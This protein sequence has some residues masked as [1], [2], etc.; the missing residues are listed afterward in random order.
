M[1]TPGEREAWEMRIRRVPGEGEGRGRVVGVRFEGGRPRVEKVTAC[2]VERTSWGLD[3]EARDGL[4][5]LLWWL[6][7]WLSS[8]KSI[9]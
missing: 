3:I 2:I 4:S 6:W 9:I 7:L 5:S 8:W 1:V